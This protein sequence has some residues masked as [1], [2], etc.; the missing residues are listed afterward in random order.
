LLFGKDFKLSS[1][2]KTAIIIGMITYNHPITS[3]IQ[4]RFSCWKYSKISRSLKKSD[5]QEGSVKPRPNYVSKS[6][7]F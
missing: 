1:N 5:P 3:I 2:T 7:L 6:K 4:Q